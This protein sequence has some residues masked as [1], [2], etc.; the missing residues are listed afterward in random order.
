MIIAGAII[1][2]ISL[3]RTNNLIGRL[4]KGN[5]RR[6]WN[7]L[8][9][10][11]VVFIV[12]FISYAAVMWNERLEQAPR[13]SDCI[14]PLI[15]SLG[16]C[17]VFL[18]ISFAFD[19]VV[20]FRRISVLGLENITDPLLGIHNRRYL[21]YRL[22][23]EV[24]RAIRY[25]L[26]LSVLLMDIDSFKQ[27]NDTYGH[28][29]GDRVLAGLGKL[30]LSTARTTDV[31]ARYGG[32]EI[33]VIATNTPVPAVLPF[34]ERLRKA[35]AD[36]VLVTPGEFTGGEEIRVTVSIG[37]AGVGPGADTAETLIKNA[38]DALL[39]A[40]NRGRNIVVIN[41]SDPAAA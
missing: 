22:K 4:P 7:V 24:S 23:Q 10:L 8:R 3:F 35:I 19:T 21:D 29:V 18:V 15:F 16:A 33:M 31:F 30:L 17:F 2:I 9:V 1:L 11:I 26:A 28:Q 37:V 27:V 34:A 39:K 12:G 41:K 40:K 6:K 32:D 14:V 5:V 36:A 25:H 20:Y 13:F 38:D